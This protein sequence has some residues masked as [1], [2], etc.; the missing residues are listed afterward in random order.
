[1]GLI[2]FLKDAGENIFGGGKKEAEAIT[3]RLTRVFG[4]R[5]SDLEVEYDKGAVTLRGTCDTQSTKEKAIL[6][7]GNIKG[8]A[9]VNGDGLQAPPGEAAA[10][11]YTVERG[12][13]LWKIA[14]NF[15]GKGGR[16]PEIFEA[17]KEVIKDPDLIYPGQ[18]LRIP[19]AK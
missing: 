14:Q 16:Y 17:N 1:M 11:Y 5:I 18:R 8:V 2:E 12:D 19:K 3:E 4:S 15:L 13:T 7:A 6:I 10:E 9:T